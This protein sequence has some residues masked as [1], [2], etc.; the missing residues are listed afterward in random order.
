M[1]NHSQAM[2]VIC[3]GKPWRQLA[4]AMLA[5]KLKRGVSGLARQKWLSNEAFNQ[6]K[7]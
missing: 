4:L 3:K 2:A 7:N 6:R 1:R 5:G